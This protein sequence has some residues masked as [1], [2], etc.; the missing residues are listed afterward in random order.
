[1]LIKLLI[2]VPEINL[3]SQFY[4]NLMEYNYGQNFIEKYSDKLEFRTHSIE[5]ILKDCPIIL[6][7]ILRWK[8]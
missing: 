4:E 5:E 3:V 2:V 6:L 7:V 8:R 1:M